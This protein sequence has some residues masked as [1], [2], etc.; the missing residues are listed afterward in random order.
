MLARLAQGDVEFVLEGGYAAVSHGLWLV[1]QDVDVC[2]RF[3]KGNRLRLQAALAGLHPGHR[4][5][6]QELPLQLSNELCVHVKNLY[7]ETDLF[8]LGAPSDPAMGSC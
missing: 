8:E 6:P 2:C 4:M 1:T 5:I 7:L 3:S